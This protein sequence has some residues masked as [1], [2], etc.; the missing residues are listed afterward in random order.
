LAHF[1]KRNQGANYIRLQFKI[2]DYQYINM[3]DYSEKNVNALVQSAEGYLFGEQDDE[4]YSEDFKK[5]TKIIEGSH[6]V[7]DKTV[8]TQTV[9]VDNKSDDPKKHTEVETVEVNEG[10]GETLTQKKSD[11]N[12]VTSTFASVFSRLFGTKKPGQ[13]SA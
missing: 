7:T 3:D 5:L 4:K 6:K 8:I 1:K 13:D 12:E 10:K 2:D 9:N 11:K